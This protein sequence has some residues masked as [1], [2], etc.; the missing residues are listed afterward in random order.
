V[1]RATLNSGSAALES[2]LAEWRADGDRLRHYGHE[3]TAAICELHA[4]QV[5]AAIAAMD[6]V[7]LTLT[8]AAVESGLS[9]DHLGRLLREGT[10]PNAGRKGAPRIRRADL[11]RSPRRLLASTP[12]ADYDPVT[13]ARALRSRR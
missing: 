1:K 11:P 12:G 10:I 9:S 3:A 13:D 7:T 6:A 5:E 2:L 4:R 8:E